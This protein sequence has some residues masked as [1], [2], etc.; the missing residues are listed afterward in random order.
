MAKR[1]NKLGPLEFWVIVFDGGKLFRTLSGVKL[2]EDLDQAHR[3]LT[4]FE[5]NGMI[6]HVERIKLKTLS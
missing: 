4:M 1:S 6:G 3:V 2:F 5:A